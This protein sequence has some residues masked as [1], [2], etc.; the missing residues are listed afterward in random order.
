MLI[1][2]CP[3]DGQLAAL[4]GISAG[5]SVPAA[6]S[7]DHSGA[8]PQDNGQYLKQ[9]KHNQMFNT[10]MFNHSGGRPQDNGQ[11]LFKTTKAQLNV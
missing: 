8:R 11:Y 3:Y 5:L 9:Q 4:P 1:C 2:P 7:V 10:L 6:A